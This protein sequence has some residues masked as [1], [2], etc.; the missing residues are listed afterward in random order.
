[1]TDRLRLNL[2][3]T[4]NQDENQ[5]TISGRGT[6]RDRKRSE[7]DQSPIRKPNI[8]NSGSENVLIIH[9]KD[10]EDSDFFKKDPFVNQTLNNQ[11]K[12]DS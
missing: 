9:K 4:Q 3:I 11:N 8:K 6:G 12:Y 2:D 7:F 5:G 1:M 10:N